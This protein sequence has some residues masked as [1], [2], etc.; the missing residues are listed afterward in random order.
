M[1]SV[2]IEGDVVRATSPEGQTAT[3]PLRKLLALLDSRG[4]GAG[5]RVYPDGLKMEIPRGPVSI[6]V[7][8]TPPRVHNFKW[9]TAESPMPF[10]P[11][12]E[13]RRVRIA[14]PYVI[15]MAVFARTR[16]GA[17]Q[18]TNANECFFRTAPLTGSDD[19]LLYPA[20][21]NISK[22]DPQEGHPIKAFRPGLNAAGEADI[23]SVEF[24]KAVQIIYRSGP[25]RFRRADV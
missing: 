20:L 18:L 8:E 5:E 21:L 23:K 3:L 24:I 4:P 25:L 9:I 15:V 7:H 2:S 22:F 6:W 19:S 14:L 12:A 10:G 1:Q 16:S 13:Y 11:L 17:L